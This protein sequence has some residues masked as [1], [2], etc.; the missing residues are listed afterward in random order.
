[1]DFEE[2]RSLST[3]QSQSHLTHQGQ[4]RAEADLSCWKEGFR[5]LSDLNSKAPLSSCPASSKV[6]DLCM[7]RD[8][9]C[10]LS[11]SPFPS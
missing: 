4:K 5:M 1:M 2:V 7:P 9:F 10:N 6:L 3:A 8:R 11:L